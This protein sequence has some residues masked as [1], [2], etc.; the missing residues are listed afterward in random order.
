MLFRS[1]KPTPS[2]LDTLAAAALSAAP[3]RGTSVKAVIY[4]NPRCSKSRA[5]LELLN[6][7]GVRPTI[8]N[9]LETPPSKVELKRLLKLLGKKPQEMIRFK[10]TVAKEHSLSLED[11]RTED[12][13]LQI[14]IDHPILIERPIVVIGNKAA[15][16]RP[17]EA[18]LS[19][20]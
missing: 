11:D 10:E 14:M 17:P 1:Q 19:I 16:G 2:K 15:L 5:T 3:K 13:W 4:H 6:R 12:A 9:Y 7:H 8:I 20:L 18:V